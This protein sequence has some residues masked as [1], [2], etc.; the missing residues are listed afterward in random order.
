MNKYKYC[1]ITL[2]F[3]CLSQGS[4]AQLTEIQLTQQRADS[5]QRIIMK[6]SLG[7]TDEQVTQVFTVR[8][9]LLQKTKLIRSNASLTVEQQNGLVT[10]IRNQANNNIQA[11]LGQTAYQHYLDMILR[12]LAFRNTGTDPLAG[13]T[14]N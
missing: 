11:I 12:K 14:E 2:L 10:D 3:I 7:I 8:D 6:D 5:L 1:F 4:E 13:A 9:T